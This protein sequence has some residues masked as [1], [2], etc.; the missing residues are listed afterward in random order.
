[1]AIKNT[2]LNAKMAVQ[3]EDAAILYPSE[4]NGQK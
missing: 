1:M 2:H 3:M 4:M